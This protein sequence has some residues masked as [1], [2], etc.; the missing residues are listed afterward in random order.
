M[1]LVEWSVDVLDS[2][3]A[4]V[5]SVLGAVGLSGPSWT[6]SQHSLC[7]APFKVLF[8]EFLHQFPR[9]LFPNFCTTLFSFF[10]GLNFRVACSVVGRAKFSIAL[11]VI[12]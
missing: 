8:F 3:V 2:V 10:L 1:D 9:F 5:S 11:S 7:G 6:S 4:A 12:S